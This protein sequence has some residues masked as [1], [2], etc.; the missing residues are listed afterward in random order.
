M[1]SKQALQIIR[2]V[3]K[4]YNS[5]AS[6]WDQSRLYPKETKKRLLKP[7][8]KEMKVLDVGCGNGL[9]IP[10][11]LKK[12][13][14]YTGV[15]ISVQL[16]KTIKEKYK[17]EIKAKKVKIIKADALKLP[18]KNNSFDFIFSFAVLHHIPSEEL[19][20][21]FFREIYRV[22]KLDCQAVI[23]VWN[24]LNSWAYKKYNIKKLL[25][26]SNLDQ[27]DLLIPWKATPGKV[28]N[29][30]IHLFN[31]QELLNLS[32]TVGFK[33]SRTYFYNRIGKQEDNGED[34]IIVLKK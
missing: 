18:F 22:L 32:K 33:N 16:L 12:G 7:I 15:D 14:L 5:I 3:A 6:Q 9:M 24:L 19:R 29:R 11:V 17:S 8:K 27:G 10:E 25:A 34:L 21:K 13:G 20:T 1:Q 30:Y 23:K 4:D 31:S 2:K 28:I 26:K